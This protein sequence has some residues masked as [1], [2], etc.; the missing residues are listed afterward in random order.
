MNAVDKQLFGANGSRSGGGAANVSGDF[1]C[2]D[3][4]QET[5]VTSLTWGDDPGDSFDGKTIPAGVK[6]WGSITDITIS[7]GL[8]VC[9]NK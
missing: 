4:I 5:V 9:Y 6:I 1:F 2:V 7:S 3:F 8:V